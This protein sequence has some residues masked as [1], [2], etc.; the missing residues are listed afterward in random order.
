[1]KLLDLERGEFMGRQE[2]YG[3]ILSEKYAQDIL[4]IGK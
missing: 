4:D 3:K 2:K 1:M